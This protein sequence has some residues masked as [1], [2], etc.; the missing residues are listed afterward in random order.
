MNKSVSLCMIVKNEEEY[1]ERCL[2]SVRGKV[3]EIIIVDTGST[4]KTR[5][6]AR[7][8]TS[9]VYSFKWVDDFSAARN[10]SIQHATSDYILVLDADEY[11][12]ATADIRNDIQSN[13]DYYLISIKN[14]LS[15]G[16]AFTH[17]AVRL[18]ANHRN[19]LFENRLHE[20]INI[21]DS[22]FSFKGGTATSLIHHTGYTNEMMVDREKI[23]RN[24]P[25]M[26]KE[27]E[28][29][30]DAYNLFN[31][32]KTY[33]S[34]DDYENAIKYFRRAYPLSSNRIF[35]PE[36]LTKLAYSLAQLKRYEDGLAILN[37]AVNLFPEDVEMRYM[38]GK[39]FMDAGYLK[40]AEFTFKEC[41]KL[42]DKGALVTEGSG[43][44]MSKHML[45]LLYEEQNRLAES[46]EMIVDVLKTK[47]S[48]APSL[49]EYFIIASKANIPLSNVYENIEKIYNIANINELQ[50]L[51]D[52]LYG[53]RHPLLNRYLMKY[54]INV[55]SNVTAAAK[56]Y[57]KKYDEAR[58]MWIGMEDIPV[59][60]ANDL[61][62]LAFILNDEEIFQRLKPLLNVGDKEARV[63]KKLIMRESVLEN[64]ISSSLGKILINLSANLI[65]LQE[66]E[67]FQ[68]ISDFMLNVAVETKVK[69]C[70]LLI[71]YSFNEI[72]IDILIEI[73]EK[74]P[75]HV[76]VIK[77]L[78]DVCY[79]SNYLDD[80]Q[81]F[82]AKLLELNPQYSTYERCYKLYEKL[83][84]AISALNVKNEINTKFPLAVWTQ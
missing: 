44:Y 39:L 30:P 15:Y 10:F 13:Y 70:E 55:Q 8:H 4:D 24:M 36:L 43:G 66:Y 9:K 51:L 54:N 18:F 5:D 76:N 52:I 37:D 64:S 6:I 63:L 22:R 75:N 14:A 80:A 48:F 32:G 16:G 74:N 40:D 81:L 21:L 61:L 57:D 68:I 78:G 20:H 56:Q 25:L 47:K 83:Q 49:R 33:M 67:I 12:D 27:A 65:V 60:N 84:D 46:Y 62:L 59:E 3:D 53:L 41:L 82:Y 38:Q 17:S 69:L 29:N 73:F 79:Q 26:L 7:E 31:M 45:A 19:L 35:M 1:L 58:E 28:E 34:A 2:E 42:G 23:K 77:L 71:D 72:A 11:L 50:L